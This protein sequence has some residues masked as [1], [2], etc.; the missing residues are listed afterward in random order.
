M[1]S[2]PIRAA[3]VNELVAANSKRVENV[4]MVVFGLGG[5]V[6]VVWKSEL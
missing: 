4:F 1:R 6:S 2:K 5:G 3:W